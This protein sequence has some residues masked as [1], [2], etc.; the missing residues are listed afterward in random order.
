MDSLFGNRENVEDFYSILGCTEHSSQEQIETEFKVRARECHPDKIVDP[1]LK[2]KAEEDFIQLNK[3]HSVLKDPLTRETYDTWKRTG[4]AMSF[5]QYLEMQSRH[6]STFHFVSE[7]KQPS[8]TDNKVAKNST[9]TSAAASSTSSHISSD[10]LNNF[11]GGGGANNRDLLS[12]FR[13]YKL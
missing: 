3:A 10:S 8:I 2:A 7:K 11:R 4:L 12:K 13:S 1:K 9:T 5:E 6:R